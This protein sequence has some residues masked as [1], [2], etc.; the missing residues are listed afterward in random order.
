MFPSGSINVIEL[1]FGTSGRPASPVQNPLARTSERIE[2]CLVHD[3]CGAWR[4]RTTRYASVD[5][6][7]SL[8]YVDISSPK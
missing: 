1:V 5:P 6:T 8:L 7:R 3:G 4:T 2:L